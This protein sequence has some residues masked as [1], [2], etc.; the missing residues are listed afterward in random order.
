VTATI[1]SSI[2]ILFI[3]FLSAL[4]N[5]INVVGTSIIIRKQ[6][7]AILESI[8]LEKTKL[9]KILVCEGLWYYCIVLFVSVLGNIILHPIFTYFRNA[10]P[11]LVFVY[12]VIPTAIM[13]LIV[14]VVCTAVPIIMYRNI[15]KS[16]LAIRLKEGDYF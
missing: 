9:R 3:M 7:F 4:I 14:F 15:N 16:T 1:I 2:G 8:G 5:Y 11:S 12:P 13:F 10:Y 6:E